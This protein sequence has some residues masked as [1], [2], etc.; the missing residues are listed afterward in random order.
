M[1][2]AKIV[3]SGKNVY[4]KVEG[5]PLLVPTYFKITDISFRDS[6]EDEEALSEEFNLKLS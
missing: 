4:L 1:N 6:L 2:K 3:K 5:E